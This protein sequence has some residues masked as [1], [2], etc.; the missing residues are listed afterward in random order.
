MIYDPEGKTLEA[1]GNVINTNEIGA[2]ERLDEVV[3]KIENGQSIPE[4]GEA[5]P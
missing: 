2:T 1:K 5:R 3:L 4:Q